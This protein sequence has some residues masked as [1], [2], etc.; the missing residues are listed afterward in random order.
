MGNHGIESLQD[1][2]NIGPPVK[3]PAPDD[4]AKEL[5]VSPTTSP[6]NMN[7]S[8]RLG[9]TVAKE[10]DIVNHVIE[11]L[12]DNVNIGPPIGQPALDDAAKDLLV[13]PTTSPITMNTSLGFGSHCC[14]GG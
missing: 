4:A 3:Q 14:R 7:T 12:Q 5:L 13:S 8:L 6:C 10:D 2:V 11:S 9:S 1:N